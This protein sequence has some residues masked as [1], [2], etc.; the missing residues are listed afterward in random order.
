MDG[1]ARYRMLLVTRFPSLIGERLQTPVDHE[2]A[3][4]ANRIAPPQS[5]GDEMDR[6]GD[7]RRCG[8]GPADERSLVV[9][10]SR[11]S[12]EG[13]AKLQG[14]QEESEDGGRLPGA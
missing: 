9:G 10:L 4:G 2:R 1:P 11:Y 14:H 3:A 12:D 6:E 5:A 8:E 13:A 7:C